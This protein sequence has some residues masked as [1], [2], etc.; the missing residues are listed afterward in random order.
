MEELRSCI[1]LADQTRFR[2]EGHRADS[3]IKP[4]CSLGFEVDNKSSIVKYESQDGAAGATR[5]NTSA[6]KGQKRS[7]VSDYA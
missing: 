3:P 2:T 4:K 7:L 1:S 6:L 5:R